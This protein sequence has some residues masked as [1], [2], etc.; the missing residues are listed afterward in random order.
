MSEVSKT[1]REYYKSFIWVDF[2]PEEARFLSEFLKRKMKDLPE[3]SEEMNLIIA[4]IYKTN[5]E[6][7]PV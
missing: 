5:V 1:I 4:L 2:T 7:C 3:D 6:G